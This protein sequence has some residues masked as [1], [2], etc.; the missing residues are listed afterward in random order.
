MYIAVYVNGERGIEGDGSST[1]YRAHWP[2]SGRQI[3][4]DF[5]ALRAQ[6]NFHSNFRKHRSTPM[7]VVENFV[8][9]F[10]PG[11]PNIMSCRDICQASS[12]DPGPFMSCH[13]ATVA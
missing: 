10:S 6:A 4:E 12:R 5:C 9:V 13:V 3:F 7:C 1:Y 8:L 2:L 11:R